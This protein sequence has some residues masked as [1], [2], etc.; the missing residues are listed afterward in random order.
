VVLEP[1]ANPAPPVGGV[2]TGCLGLPCLPAPP[3]GFLGSA[4]LVVVLVVA[5]EVVLVA[6]GVEVRAVEDVEDDLPEPQPLAASTSTSVAARLQSFIAYFLAQ[7]V[8]PASLAN[9]LLTT[10]GTL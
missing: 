6:A 3:A 9:A 5:L 1:G 10:A 4:V 7:L 2:V 8:F